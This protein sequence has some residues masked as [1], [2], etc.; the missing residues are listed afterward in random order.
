MS[1]NAEPPLLRRIRHW[2]LH[3]ILRQSRSLTER[4][5][6]YHSPA[7]THD[8]MLI[9]IT[10]GENVAQFLWNDSSL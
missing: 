4:G 6:A 3:S 8:R 9:D 5:P 7:Y 1:L 2:R 10:Y